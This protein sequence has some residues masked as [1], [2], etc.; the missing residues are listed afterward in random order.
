VNL[1]AGDFIETW[2]GA[3]VAAEAHRR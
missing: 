3:D 2:E 1:D